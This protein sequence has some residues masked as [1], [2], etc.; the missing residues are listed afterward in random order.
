MNIEYQKFSD[1]RRK[2]YC[3]STTIIRENDTKH[4]VKEAIFTEGME[5]LNNMLRYS[6]ELEKTYPNVYSG[7]NDFKIVFIC[8]LLVL[9]NGAA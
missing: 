6:K 9:L 1:E 8:K 3:I 2:K 7:V 5:H 4:V